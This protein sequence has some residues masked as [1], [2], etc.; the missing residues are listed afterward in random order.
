MNEVETPAE[1]IDPFLAAAGW[2][3][4]VESR[5]RR[6]CLVM[7]GYWAENGKRPN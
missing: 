5:I 7:L 4:V 2:G 6:E 3:V 1:I